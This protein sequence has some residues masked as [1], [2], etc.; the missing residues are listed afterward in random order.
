MKERVHAYD[1][2]V[3][4]LRTD[5]HQVDA[6]ATAAAQPGR[7]G[8]W[9]IAALGDGGTPQCQ[10]ALAAIVSDSARPANARLAALQSLGRTAAPSGAA[11]ALVRTLLDDAVLGFQAKLSLGSVIYRIKDSDPEAARSLLRSLEQGAR[12][13]PQRAEYLQALGNAGHPE[14]MHTI[15]KAL[16]DGIPS[17]RAAAAEALRRVPSAGVEELLMKVARD[18]QSPEVRIAALESARQRPPSSSVVSVAL[19]LARHDADSPVRIKAIAVAADFAARTRAK[20]AREV[21]SYLAEHE[22][23][24]SIR[25]SAVSALER[26]KRAG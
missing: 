20:E 15:E 24:E 14:S 21:F 16:L 2:L 26:L 1:V 17:V 3:S 25:K 7:I 23:N 9:A 19:D 22:P 11:N 18:D 10:V 12:Q 13:S 6:V 5:P 8:A 4:L